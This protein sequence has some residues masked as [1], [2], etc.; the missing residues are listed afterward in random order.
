MGKN[1]L[2][3]ITILLLI[4]GFVVQNP[5]SASGNS[6]QGIKNAVESVDSAIQYTVNGNLT[7]AQNAYDQFNKTWREIEVG[8]K[9]HSHTAYRDIESNMGKV[10]YAFTLKKPDQV[11]QALKDL[12]AVNEKYPYYQDFK[13]PAGTYKAL[14]EDLTTLVAFNFIFCDPDFPE[15]FVYNIVKETYENVNVLKTAN[16]TFEYTDPQYIRYVPV[17]FHDGA[18]KYYKEK[19]ITIPELPPAPVQ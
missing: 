13:I 14:K 11:L 10:V 18:I 9:E 6:S 16:P 7:E 5:V 15:E 17:P 2:L 8:I 1:L 12:K 3:K 4:I 19:G